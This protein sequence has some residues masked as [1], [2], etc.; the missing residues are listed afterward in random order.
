[1]TEV[2]KRD[3]A[4]NRPTDPALEA[5]F[6]R[7]RAKLV[8]YVDS[9][10]AVTLYPE[11]D[12]SAPAHYARA[13]AYHLG[14]YPEKALSEIDTLLAKSPDDPFFLEVKGQILLESGR[15]RE[16]LPILRKAVAMAPDQPMI[17]VL[18]GHALVATEDPANLAEAKEVLK[19]A[20]GRDNENPFAWL[21]LGMIYDREG[22]RPRAALAMAESRN[23]EG[24]PKLA[25]ASAKMAMA[26]IPRGTPDYI[27]AQDIALVSQAEL[28]KDKKKKKDKPASE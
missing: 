27:R 22:D 21:Q 2:Y 14:A 13:Y 24:K 25:L 6:Q 1:M 16:A 11:S 26:G 9:R 10:N 7:V 19:A 20:V 4:W 15:P 3:P 8:G 17:S 5:R 12:K 23:L 28:D 18:L